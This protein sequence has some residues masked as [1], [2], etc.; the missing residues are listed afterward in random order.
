MPK[1]NWH[2]EHP[3]GGDAECGDPQPRIGLAEMQDGANYPRVAES[4]EEQAEVDAEHPGGEDDRYADYV[5]EYTDDDGRLFYAVGRW[6]ESA[7]QFQRPL[8]GEER[9]LTGCHTEFG[10]LDYMPRY[11]KRADAEQ[12]ARELWYIR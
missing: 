7:G 11:A 1:T 10:G 4:A 3:G 5:H 8:D 9:Q 12:R 6:V 2:D